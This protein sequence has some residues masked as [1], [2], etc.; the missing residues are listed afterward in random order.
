MKSFVWVEKHGVGFGMRLAGE[1]AGGAVCCC[2][3]V[4]RASERVWARVSKVEGK[5][6]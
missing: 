6:E 2:G 4:L 5:R 1:K 3:W